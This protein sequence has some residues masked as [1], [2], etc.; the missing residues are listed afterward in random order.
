MKKDYKK[1]L[2]RNAWLTVGGGV[3]LCIAGI[4]FTVVSY[5]NA[6][7]GETYTIWW[8][9]PLVGIALIIRAIIAFV[10]MPKEVAK[11][12]AAEQAAAKPVEAPKE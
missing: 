12:E 6:G 1:D 3:L 2:T 4:V 5:N 10:R 11:M 9:L 7:P 8:G